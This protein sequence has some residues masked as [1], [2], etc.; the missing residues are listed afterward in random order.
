M[1]DISSKGPALSYEGILKPDLQAQ[2]Q[3]ILGAYILNES[4][5]TISNNL[6]LST[7]YTF[8]SRTSIA[9]PHVSGT[10][11]LLKAA[12]LDWSPSAI[13][14][15]MMSTTNPLDNTNQQIKY[16]TIGYKATTPLGF[17][18]RLIDP[19]RA[20]DPGLIYDASPQDF[21]NLVCSMNFTRNQ[22]Q[23]IIRSSFNCSNPSSNLNYPSFVALFSFAKRGTLVTRMF[24]R[25]IT[26][27]GNGTTRYR[28]QLNAPVNTTIKIG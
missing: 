23:T 14:S 10:A 22:T 20:F 19:N 1:S 27:V 12:H 15:A 11:A 6:F 9:Y 21:V 25:T 13:Q 4:Q 26:N 28:V 17:G 16:I 18:S 3:T 8:Q 24:Q 2:G 5:A 7:D